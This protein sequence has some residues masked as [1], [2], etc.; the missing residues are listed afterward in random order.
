VNE[1]VCHGI[2]DARPLEEGDIIN[3]DVSLFYEGF[4]SDLNATYPVGKVS[5]DHARL[6]R[7]SRKCLDEA[8][9]IC[10]PGVE[11]KE[12]G[13][14]IE[15]VATKEGFSSN[16]TYVGHGINQCVQVFSA[17]L[18]VASDLSTPTRMFH[19]AL[20]NVSH[21]AN[22]RDTGKMKVGVT[23]T[24]EPMINMK[25][26]E[27]IHWNDNVGLLLCLAPICHALLTFREPKHSG[28]ARLSMEDSRLNSRR[29]S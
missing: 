13:N 16:R 9:R 1:V 24:C 14:V 15:P 18:S 21:F 29:Q 5:D 7:T 20:P 12:L 26:H 3:L 17:V 27:G 22:S 2:P 23:F 28:P 8:I 19:P 11:Y 10:K 6:I 4:H 25:R